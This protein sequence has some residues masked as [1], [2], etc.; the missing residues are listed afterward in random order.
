MLSI[1]RTDDA[2]AMSRPLPMGEPAVRTDH[3]ETEALHDIVNT[4]MAQA[5]ASGT[6]IAWHGSDGEASAIIVANGICTRDEASACALRAARDALVST[7]SRDAVHR[8]TEIDG[9]DRIETL[10]IRADLGSVIATLTTVH[11]G[12]EPASLIR[13]RGILGTIRNSV[14]IL[15]RLWHRRNAD[16]ANL[17]ELTLAL[18][19]SDVATLL[20]DRRCHIRFANSVARDLL[21]R[22]D[23]VCARGMM[24]AATNLSDTMRLQAAIAHVCLQ[25]DGAGAPSAAPVLALTRSRGRPLLV[26][27]IAN[28]TGPSADGDQSATVRL[29]DPE[30]DLTPLVEPACNLYRLSPVEARLACLIATGRSLAEAATALHIRE[31]TARTYLKQV[32]LKTDTKRQAELVWLLLKSCVGT[33]PGRRMSF[34]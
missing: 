30:R 1:L 12:F 28:D 8:R 16:L 4:V 33:A 6:L 34:L 24:L 13:T 2:S 20:V 29:F 21:H 9:A 26:S 15:L 27:V 32:F 25:F 3:D 22:A 17:R 18:D 23:G 5:G 11:A 10:T 19:C 7:D 31:Q 14:E